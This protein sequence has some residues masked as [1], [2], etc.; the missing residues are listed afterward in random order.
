VFAFGRRRYLWVFT[1]S[2]ILVLYTHNWGLWLAAGATVA[3]IPCAV[4]ASDRSRLWRDAAIGFG[5]AGLAYLPWVPTLVFQAAHTGAPWSPRPLPRQAVSVVAD[6][7]GD[8]HERVLVVLL[9]VAGPLLWSLLRSRGPL[10]PAVAASALIATV[11][12]GLGWVAAQ[13]SPSWVPRYLA[14]CAPAILLLA[15]VGLARTGAR[16][17]VA[18]GLILAFWVQPLARASG[19]RP[20]RT[21]GDKATVQPLARAVAGHLNPGDLVIAMQM[22]EVPVLAYYLPKGLRFAT[23]MGPVADP[24]IADWRDA[25]ARMRSTTPATALKP[26]LDRSPVGTDVVL[27]CAEPGSGPASLPW[28]ALMGRHCEEWRSALEADP[29]FQPFPIDTGSEPS[30]HGRRPVLGFT[31]TAA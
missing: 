2:L 20:A 5:I 12:V 14:V 7:L 25:L 28:F 23:A 13:V 6:L 16:G 15:A 30:T 27:I 4:A 31:K 19:L 3:L 24:G 11:P 29:R 1:P 22:E 10:R 26:E 9:F 17:L 18:L 21:L 8:T